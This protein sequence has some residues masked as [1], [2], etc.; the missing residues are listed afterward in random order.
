M[1]GSVCRALRDCLG[2]PC[3][4]AELED[5]IL[6]EYHIT[7]EKQKLCLKGDMTVCIHGKELELGAFPNGIEFFADELYKIEQITVKTAFFTTVENYTSWLRCDSSK[8]ALFYLGGYATRYQ[9][10]FLEKNIFR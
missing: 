5:E 7:R 4:P 1:L 10:D 9:R 6:E 8:T 2:R 3:G